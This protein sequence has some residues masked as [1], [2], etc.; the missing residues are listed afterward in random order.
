MKFVIDETKNEMIH[1]LIEGGKNVMLTG[2][3]GSGKTTYCVE[4]AKKLGMDY[5]VVNCG[6]T[7]DAR[8]SLLG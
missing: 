7:Q 8:T 5:I 4:V 3:T 2:A 1:T 6:S